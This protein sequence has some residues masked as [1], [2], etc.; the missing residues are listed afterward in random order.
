MPLKS[1]LPSEVRRTCPAVPALACDS[2]VRVVK[3][4]TAAIT[5][6]TAIV[7]TTCLKAFR[8]TEAPFAK[9]AQV[10]ASECARLNA[11]PV[12]TVVRELNG[13]VKCV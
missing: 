8:M 13:E 5:D 4:N 6:I 10:T 9:Q 12:A 1:G 7:L 11:A 3:T 2:P